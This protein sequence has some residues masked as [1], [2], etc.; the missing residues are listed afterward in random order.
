MV[1]PCAPHRY[2]TP[3]G[4]GRLGRSLPPTT[5]GHN[6]STSRP[7]ARDDR[8]TRSAQ[9]PRPSSRHLHAGHRLANQQAPARPIPEPQRFPGF[10]ATQI[11][12]RVISGSLSLAFLVHTCRARGATFP[13][14]SP[15]RLLTAA[16]HG[17]LRPPPARR[18]RRAARPLDPAPPS[19]AQHRLQWSGLLHPASFNVR[20]H[21]FAR[22]AATSSP[23]GRVSATTA[24]EQPGQRRLR[25]PEPRESDSERPP[26]R[27]RQ[28]ARRSLRTS[29]YAAMRSCSAYS[30][31]RP[32][33][34]ASRAADSTS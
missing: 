28:T 25:C 31:G 26:C 23:R 17:G 27:C 9:K 11:F 20:V 32:P 10:D 14:R 19:P 4:F 1:R 21:T 7:R 34:A 8:F 6:R 3:R 18:P 15:P 2:S 12:R 24:K 13:R 22:H 30:P 33:A 16:A 5:E 29:S